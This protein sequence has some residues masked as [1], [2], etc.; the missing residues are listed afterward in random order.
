VDDSESPCESIG[1][2]YSGLLKDDL[3]LAEEYLLNRNFND[4]ISIL[5]TTNSQEN[6][7]NELSVRMIEGDYVAAQILL[8]SHVLPGQDVQ[9]FKEIVSLYINVELNEMDEISRDINI[10]GLK[11]ICL[12]ANPSSGFA[13]ALHYSLTGQFVD[14]L[15][16]SIIDEDDVQERKI[17]I[18]QDNFV[19]NSINLHPNPTSRFVFIEE[20]ETIDKMLIYNAQGYEIEEMD[21]AIPFKLDVSNW[22][23]GVYYIRI[24]NINGEKMVKRL[25]KINSNQ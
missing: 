20:Y 24:I 12:N 17:N 5:N 9:D 25:L 19:E 21:G 18:G 7:F 14:N 8:N 22:E 23:N 1:G 15:D 4:A 3:A 10:T 2:E 11:Q 6:F 16:M 13:Q